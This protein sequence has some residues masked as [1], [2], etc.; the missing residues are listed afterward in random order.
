MPLVGADGLLEPGFTRRTDLTTFCRGDNPPVHDRHSLPSAIGIVAALALGACGSLL[1][2]PIPTIAVSSPETSVL[3][4][5]A[6]AA[7]GAP[8]LQTTALPTSSVPV[9]PTNCFVISVELCAQADVIKYPSAAGAPPTTIVAFRLPKGTRVLSP[10]PGEAS[11][12]RIKEPSEFRG[13]IIGV[14]PAPFYRCD[15]PTFQFRGALAPIAPEGALRQ[16]YARVQVGQPIAVVESDEPAGPGG[17]NVFFTIGG[18]DAAR[19]YSTDDASTLFPVAFSKSPRILAY[20]GPD[21]RATTVTAPYYD[22]PSIPCVQ[23]SFPSPG[24]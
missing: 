15:G 10:S 17:Y 16:S 3:A 9:T 5:D 1:S 19:K 18:S 23:S 12:I 21:V 4:S 24:R 8:G 13:V 14:V 7:S 11:S 2:G 20:E 6:P 22:D